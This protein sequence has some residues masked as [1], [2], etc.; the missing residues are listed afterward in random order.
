MVLAPHHSQ[1][2]P[3]V[4]TR[5]DLEL[6]VPVQLR[7][8]ML[9]SSAQTRALDMTEEA[10]VVVAVPPFEDRY[11]STERASFSSKTSTHIVKGTNRRNVE[12]HDW[13][14]SGSEDT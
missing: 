11:N 9:A 7:R 12:A 8:C 3:E 4:K 13:L 6:Q 2:V 1:G 14:D 5:E 10:P